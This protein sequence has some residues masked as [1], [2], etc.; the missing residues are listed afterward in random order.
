VSFTDPEAR[1][2]VTQQHSSGCSLKNVKKYTIRLSM[3]H[4]TSWS[5]SW[6]PTIIRTPR[7]WCLRL[8]AIRR[9]YLHS[10]NCSSSHWS[11]AKTW[12]WPEHVVLR[13]ITIAERPVSWLPHHLVVTAGCGVWSVRRN[14]LSNSSV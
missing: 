5:Q 8:Q 3:S 4:I 1:K 7:P 13:P 14:P 10:S 11:W 6:S 9:H 2:D 12:A